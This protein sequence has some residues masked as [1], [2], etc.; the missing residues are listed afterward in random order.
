[1]RGTRVLIAPVLMCTACHRRLPVGVDMVAAMFYVCRA[2]ARSRDGTT[3][4]T[5]C[6]FTEVP[7]VFA[8]PVQGHSG[9]HYSCGD[10]VWLRNDPAVPTVLDTDGEDADRAA[11]R[12]IQAAWLRLQQRRK[13][14]RFEVPF[15]NGVEVA[16]TRRRR[17]RLA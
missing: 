3:A 4:R 2:S 10:D 8:R 1:M 5:A 7:C 17:R 13:R 11:G 16:R 9:L 14:I 6:Q 15:R 12:A